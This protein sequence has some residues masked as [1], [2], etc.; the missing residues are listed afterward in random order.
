[1]AFNNSESDDDILS[2]I[3]PAI[4]LAVAD[5]SLPEKLSL[6]ANSPTGSAYI[7]DLLG[8]GHLHRIYRVLRMTQQSFFALRDWCLL[9]T[10]LRTSRGKRVSIE[11]KLIMFLWTINEGPSNR[12]VQERFSHSGETISRCFHEVL[13]ALLLLHKETVI[14]PV[15][16]TPVGSRITDDPKYGP[17]FSDCVGAL[18]G[19]HIAMHI[20]A[21]N[22]GRYRNRK[23][24]I[25]QNVLAV[26]NFDMEFTYILGGWEGS[27][28]DTAVLRSAVGSHGFKTP[29]RKYWLGD[30]GY[31]N[32][33]T[34]LTPYRGVRYHLKE[35]YKSKQKPQNAKELFNLRHAS[36]RNVI[37]RIFGV[38]KRKYKI[39]RGSEYSVDTQVRLVHVL[40][41]LH[42]FVRARE[43][44]NADRF[45]EKEKDQDINIQPSVQ[46]PDNIELS[47]KAMDIFRDELAIR[48]WQDYIEHLRKLEAEPKID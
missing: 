40:T 48:M 23:G 21:I 25:S 27:A 4:M 41:A 9:Y 44:L 6:Y 3:V 38:L 5:Q 24:W 35:Q 31:S 46:L 36:L 8:C 20:P 15:T 37:E 32:S 34:I 30:A 13:E 1:M 19:T 33:E 26:C 29:K 28:H 22:Q 42:N 39:L 16:D 7:D 14:L 18:D 47:S 11:E 10:E 45:L 12:V 2:T 17:Y 43:G